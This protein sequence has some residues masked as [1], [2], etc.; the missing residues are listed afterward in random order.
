MRRVVGLIAITL[1]CSATGTLA[2]EIALLSGGAVKSAMTEAIAVWEKKTGHR[3]K[4]TFAPAGEMQKR[5]AAGE[6]FDAVIMPTENLPALER[7][8]LLA[9]GSQ[10]AVAGASIGIA[11]KKGAPLPDIS[12]A[13][14]VKRLLVGAK[15]LTYMDPTRGTSGKYVDEVVLPKLGIRD[16]V[17]AKT[18]FG[19]GGTIADKVARGEVEIAIHQMTE[20]LPVEGVTPV[21]LLP[22]ELQKTTIYT[23]AVMRNSPNAAEAKSLLDYAASP[24]ARPLFST[25]GFSAP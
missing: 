4:A 10:R 6:R 17:R 25:R 12:T 1:G 9:P 3:V 14:A 2:A 22:P 24:E 21:G 15:S 20:I 23:G 7:D 13:D 11:V 16:E 8:G 18:K 5:L 19:E